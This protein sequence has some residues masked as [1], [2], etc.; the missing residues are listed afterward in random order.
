MILVKCLGATVRPQIGCGLVSRV[1]DCPFCRGKDCANKSKCFVIVATWRVRQKAHSMLGS[2]FGR[3]T[4]LS[5]GGGSGPHLK[6]LPR[7]LLCHMPQSGTINASATQRANMRMSS[8]SDRSCKA[9][10]YTWDRIEAVCSRKVPSAVNAIW[11]QIKLSCI[12]C[13]CRRGSCS[14][15]CSY[16]W[17]WCCSCATLPHSCLF[18]LHTELAFDSD[19]I[20]LCLR[21]VVC[22]KT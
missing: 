22:F 10:R 4:H 15:K 16:C 12:C 8:H 13:C 19:L 1:F 18:T 9:V 17:F 6:P 2:H 20:W 3:F 7:P 21:P 14:Y 11:N 5:T